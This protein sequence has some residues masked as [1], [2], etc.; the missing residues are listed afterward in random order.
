MY[1]SAVSR[2]HDPNLGHQAIADVDKIETSHL[3]YKTHHAASLFQTAL[4]QLLA[5]S[6]FVGALTY[7]YA[8]GTLFLICSHVNGPVNA[9]Q[10]LLASRS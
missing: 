9:R 7:N 8:I 5:L 4:S 6:V 1:V 2:F 10:A 3:N